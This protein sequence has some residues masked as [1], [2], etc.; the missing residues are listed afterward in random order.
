MSMILAI[1]IANIAAGVMNIQQIFQKR[2]GRLP[3]M[4]S[5]S[6]ENLRT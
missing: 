1:R 5:M 2:F 4:Y 6:S 3:V